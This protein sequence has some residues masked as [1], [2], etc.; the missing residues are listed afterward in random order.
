ML[1][2]LRAEVDAMRPVPPG[3]YEVTTAD[4][5][6]LGGN[7]G[8]WSYQS[9]WEVLVDVPRDVCT[10]QMSGSSVDNFEWPPT[11]YEWL[12][13]P[14][15]LTASEFRDVTEIALGTWNRRLGA[16]YFRYAGDCEP[17]G[18]G[19]GAQVVVVRFELLRTVAQA[20]PT[21]GISVSYSPFSYGCH[22][23]YGWT[24]RV[25]SRTRLD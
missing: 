9:T 25:R 13:H 10:M 4:L 23:L 8:H 6:E 21:S 22:R 15:W 16:D 1:A 14:A 11:E 2:A 20:A 24:S 12:D 19:P 7:I 3:A 18:A 5:Q 17:L